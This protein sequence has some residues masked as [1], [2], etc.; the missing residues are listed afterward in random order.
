MTQDDV[1]RSSIMVTIIMQWTALWEQLAN[2][3]TFGVKRFKYYCFG[4][5]LDTAIELECMAG[6]RLLPPNSVETE[7]YDHNY[8]I[9][10]L[11]AYRDDTDTTRV[12]FYSNFDE[13]NYLYDPA[14]GYVCNTIPYGIE[15]GDPR[16]GMEHDEYGLDERVTYPNDAGPTREYC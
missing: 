8:G 2:T 6:L 1:R 10:E 11:V 5:P 12:E 7:T 14:L 15:R 13:S 16:Y 4:L 3:P 9:D